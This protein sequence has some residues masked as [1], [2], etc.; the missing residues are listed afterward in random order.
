[1]NIIIVSIAQ[2]QFRISV[3][4]RVFLGP[5][6]VNGLCE[7]LRQVGFDPMS[8][9]YRLLCSSSIDFPEDEEGIPEGFEAREVLKEAITLLLPEERQADFRR[10]VE[11]HG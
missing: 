4:D 1:M 9:V 5:L 3:N 10:A 2:A 7:L 11:C 8:P 6:S